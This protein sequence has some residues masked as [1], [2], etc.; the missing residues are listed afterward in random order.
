MGRYD[1]RLKVYH[2]GTWKNVQQLRVYRNGSWI[3]FGN[4]ESSITKSLYVRQNGSDKRITR[5]RVDTPRS[6]TVG[7]GYHQGA[8][9]ISTQQVYCFNNTGGVT[10]VKF[11]ARFNVKAGGACR[12]FEFKST[13][14][15]NCSF[16]AGIKADGTVYYTLTDYQWAGMSWTHNAGRINMGYD[17][18][19][20]QTIEFVGNTGSNTLYV[21]VNGTRYDFPR[22]TAWHSNSTGSVG[23]N[24]LRIA[25]NGTFQINTAGS[26]FTSISEDKTTNYYTET[27]WV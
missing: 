3:D 12:L 5:N 22:H 15:N 17:Q 19:S 11:Y 14:F 2:N 25:T 27:R 9:S 8:W 13:Y 23:D 24:N 21:Y 7:L 20:W 18:S 6:E 1:G 10:N 26:A 4:N 16:Y